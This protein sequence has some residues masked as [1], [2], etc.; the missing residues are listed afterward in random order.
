DVV[1]KILRRLAHRF[2]DVEKRGEVHHREDA[3]MPQRVADRRAIGDV[4]R[5]ERSVLHRFAMT[6]DEVVED[7][8]RVAGAVQR[9]RRMAADV[10]GAAGHE[11]GAPATGQWRNT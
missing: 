6:G 5:D 7:D 10:A 11:D 1:A 4:T 3:V 2:A 8:D 9:L